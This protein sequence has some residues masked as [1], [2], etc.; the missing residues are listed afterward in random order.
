MNNDDI[1]AYKDLFI[2][3]ANDYVHQL[4]DALHQLAVN[5]TDQKAIESIHI[6]AHSLKS[7]NLAM[8][9]ES[10]GKL[11][12]G[13]EMLF[14]NIKNMHKTVSS[15]LQQ[16]LSQWIDAYTSSLEE[17]NNTN[18]EKDLSALQSEVTKFSS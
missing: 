1:I 9:F 16:A 10:N 11:F 7:Q 2:Q 18:K 6:A 3:T 12:L 5:P 14:D 13:I 4:H 8:G 15:E 17:I